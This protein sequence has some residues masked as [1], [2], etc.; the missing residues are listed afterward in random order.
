VDELT[1][2]ELA[3]AD[4]G[5]GAGVEHQVPQLLRLAGADVR[6]RVRLVAALH[7][8]VED[9]RAGRLREGR[10]LRE[11]VLGVLHG[12]GGPDA[13][14]HHALQPELPVLD[15][16]DVLQLGGETRHTAQCRA[17]TAVV[18]IAVTLVVDPATPGDVLFHQGV[19]P[20]VGIGDPLAMVWKR[21][22]EGHW[23]LTSQGGE[24][25]GR[26]E[27]CAAYG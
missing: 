16:G 6:R 8:A 4:D 2:A 11:G 22:G 25:G 14:E 19:G 20:A 7:D 5:V 21:G 17:L 3:V 24:R 1:R 10:E 12:A 27:P 18:L 13:D 15:L 23:V 9:H 26:E